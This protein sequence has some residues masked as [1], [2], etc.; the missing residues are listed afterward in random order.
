ML[1]SD[2]SP[3]QRRHLRTKEAILD[4]ARQ[5]IREDGPEGLS[6]RQIADRIDYSAAGLY[7]YFGSKEEI[8]TAVCH[9]GH[10]RLA[11]YM[12][13]VEPNLSPAV[14]LN[15]IGQQYISFAL[16]NPDLYKLMFMTVTLPQDDEPWVADDESSYGI[17]LRAIQNGIDSGDFK[18][19]V[20]YGLQEMAYAA[21]ALVHGIA[22]LRLT[23]LEQFP[24]DFDV[25]DQE[26]LRTLG[27]G[28]M[29]G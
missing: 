3:R 10:E 28:L 22:M 29:A 17:L 9:Q 12:M 8:V 2:L 7:E 15:A 20:G 14:Y 16:Q 27:D 5:I 19:R 26:V 21:W 4:A 23:Y 6:M 1:D 11:A 13:Q 25:V 18:V 24:A